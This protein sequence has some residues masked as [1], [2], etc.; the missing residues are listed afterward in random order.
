[1][2]SNCDSVCV[3]AHEPRVETHETST[4]S[5]DVDPSTYVSNL[6]VSCHLAFERPHGLTT[7]TNRMDILRALKSENPPT[8]VVTWLDSKLDVLQA[9]I[10]AAHKAV[11]ERNARL[12]AE[13][14]IH[15]FQKWGPV[16]FGATDRCKSDFYDGSVRIDGPDNEITFDPAFEVQV[17]ELAGVAGLDA[18]NVLKNLHIGRACAQRFIEFIHVPAPPHH[19]DDEEEEK[20]DDEV[21]PLEDSSDDEEGEESGTESDSE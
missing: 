7:I 8:E 18:D 14:V 16:R 3:E 21:P 4:Q 20:S 5:I 6:P 1:M 9:E 13:R 11:H 2:S 10:D 12:L 17:R 15:K 19:S